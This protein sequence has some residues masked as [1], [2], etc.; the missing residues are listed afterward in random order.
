M[1][2]CYLTVVTIEDDEL[3]D[4]LVAGKYDKWLDSHT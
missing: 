3:I 2:L 4:N 1:C